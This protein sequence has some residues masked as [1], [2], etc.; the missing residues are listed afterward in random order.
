L[1]VS[2]SAVAR[3]QSYKLVAIYNS[4]IV[5]TQEITLYKEQNNI[6]IEQIT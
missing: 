2:S 1:T 3:E 4:S 6:N 5:M